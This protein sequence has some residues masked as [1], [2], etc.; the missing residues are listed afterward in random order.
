MN[1]LMSMRNE[2]NINL[3]HSSKLEFNETNSKMFIS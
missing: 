2:S 1:S 3:K